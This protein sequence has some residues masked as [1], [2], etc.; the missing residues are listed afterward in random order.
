MIGSHVGMSLPCSGLLLML[1]SAMAIARRFA[2][3]MT[4]NAQ[5]LH[6][7]RIPCSE[8]CRI[9][10]RTLQCPSLDMSSFRL[11]WKKA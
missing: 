9:D 4:C 5:L 6:T 8:D 10:M 2:V 11:I 1:M 3:H 7:A